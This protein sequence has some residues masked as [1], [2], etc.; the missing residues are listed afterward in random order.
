LS[1]YFNNKFNNRLTLRTGILLQNQFLDT[2][3]YTRD[4]VPDLNGDGRPDL[5]TQ[6]DFDGSFTTAEAYAQTQWRVAERLTLNAGLHGL[7]FDKTS[8]VAVEPRVALN[9]QTS[10]KST[11]NLG[12][13][14]HN[15]TQPLPVFLF[16]ERQSDGSFKETN[17]D[18]DFTRSQHFVLG[19]DYKPAPSWRVKAETYY[20]LL[21]QIPVESTPSSFALLNA[22]ADFVF[23]EKNNLVN[24]GT[25][26][27][28]GAEITVEKFFSDGWYSLVTVS[29][30]DSKYKGSDGIERSTAFDGG[31]VAN[32]LAGK[33]FKLGS[34]GRRVLTLDT[35]VTSAGGRPYTPV[36]LAASKAIG[37]EVLI[38]NQAYSLRLDGYF[39]WDVK[40]G[41]RINSPK[42]KLSQSFFF[43][44]QNVTNNQNIFAMRYNKVRNEVG[45]TYQI[46]FFPD[47]MYRVEF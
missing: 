17:T 11:F 1:S 10:P 29:V 39:R 4:G 16:R 36:D 18:L 25:G 43:D 24:E 14:L 40:I 2:Y 7:Y 27:N 41:M 28:V 26:T 8:D 30:F 37:K 31:Y 3:V 9:W 19:W 20:Q 23:P 45:K 13:G 21:S 32:V 42:R 35:K 44:F 12:Y 33:E 5:Y 38:E 46:G 6:R 22:G 15:Q 47:L 34:S